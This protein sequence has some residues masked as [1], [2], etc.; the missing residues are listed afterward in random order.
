MDSIL[1]AA[2]NPVMT[3]IMVGLLGMKDPLRFEAR[4]ALA[5][6]KDAVAMAKHGYR[7]VSSRE[8]EMPLFGITYQRV[9]YE[10]IDPPKS[11]GA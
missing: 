6:E 11:T 3:A 2:V 10:L 1:F 9:T 8:Y 7:I 5:M 4:V